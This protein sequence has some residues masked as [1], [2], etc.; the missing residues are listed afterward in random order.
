MI[1][2]FFLLLTLV[3][4]FAA[5]SQKLVTEIQ[6][7]PAGMNSIKGMALGDSL[8]C[9]I[10]SVSS[11]KVQALWVFPDGTQAEVDNSIIGQKIIYACVQAK[12]GIYLF[13]I[14]EKKNEVQLKALRFDSTLKKLDEIPG[15]FNLQGR[16]F[17]SYVDGEDL[18]LI[19]SIKNQ[20][21]LQLVRLRGMTL[22]SEQNFNLPMDI[23][24]L[25]NLETRYKDEKIPDLPFNSAASIKMVK[26]D[27]I[28]WISYDEY[29]DPTATSVSEGQLFKTTVVKLNLKE[30]ENVIVK[31]FYENTLSIFNSTIRDGL[32]FR[33]HKDKSTHLDAIDIE[34]GI[35]VFSILIPERE[36]LPKASVYSRIGRN[37]TVQVLHFD[38]PFRYFGLNFVYIDPL[39]DESL[40]VTLGAKKRST[41]S[42]PLIHSGGVAIFLASALANVLVKELGEGDT[43]YTYCF[44]NVTMK[45][46]YTLVDRSNGIIDSIDQYEIFQLPG[47]ISFKGYLP[48]SSGVYGFYRQGASKSIKVVK[49]DK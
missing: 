27:E 38:Q 25:K 17:G 13:Y 8:F 44:L 39:E 45:G 4:C 1:K 18:V 7:P 31:T 28:I 48:V 30:P 6:L 24:K 16:L 29:L 10:T 11:K 9:T 36:K 35:K 12:E 32:L 2:S 3:Y 47:K 26:H 41:S 40:S 23:S 34:S 49:F 46:E 37:N 5:E 42:F 15:E 14:E 22:I 19:K 21:G 33:V 43:D 20:F